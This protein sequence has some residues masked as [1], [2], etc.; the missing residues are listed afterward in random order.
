MH[1]LYI[2]II[3]RRYLSTNSNDIRPRSTE[4]HH[5][6]NVEFGIDV[7]RVPVIRPASNAI[8]E[9]YYAAEI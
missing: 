1:K 9:R 6:L 4:Q 2:N 5:E 3:T 8:F 7:R